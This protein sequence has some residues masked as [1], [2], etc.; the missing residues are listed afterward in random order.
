[1]TCATLSSLYG[2]MESGKLYVA[3]VLSLL[4]S[5]HS[6]T[7]A[8]NFRRD[9]QQGVNYAHFVKNPSR[10]LN[11]AVLVSL[12]VSRPQECTYH[13]INHQECYSVNF[14][15]LSL[16]GRHMCELLNADK[17]QN[18]GNLVH[19]ETCDHYNIKVS[20]FKLF[21]L[22]NYLGNFFVVGI[23]ITCG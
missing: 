17:F 15:A 4:M 22:G 20:C 21:D 9:G 12:V 8:K 5:V 3:L 14:A 18:S 19:S 16:E 1:M 13:C 11:T 2:Q 7:S 10:R 6:S 23:M